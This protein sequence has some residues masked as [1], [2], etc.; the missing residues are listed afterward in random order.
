MSWKHVFISALAFA[1]LWGVFTPQFLQAGTSV[2]TVNNAT[3]IVGAG[4]DLC[5]DDW[6]LENGGRITGF[7]TW[8]STKLRSSLVPYLLLL[9]D[10]EPS[11]PLLNAEEKVEER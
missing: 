4:A 11:L 3:I 6:A 8:C 10:D 9:S 1:G 5:A 7:G 2:V